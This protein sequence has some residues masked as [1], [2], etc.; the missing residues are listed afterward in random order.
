M[1][2][3]LRPAGFDPTK[4]YPMAYLIHGGPQSSWS[5][6][7]STR[8]NPQVYTGA[9]YVAVFINFHGSTSYGQE[10]TNSISRNWGSYPYEDIMAS[11][12][13]VFQT[14]PFIDSKRVAGLGASYGGYMINWLNGHTEDH[15]KCFVNHDGLFDLK[16]MYYST[17]ELYFPEFDMGG[18]PFDNP[19]L[20]DKWNPSKFVQKWRTPTLVIHGGKDYRVPPDQGFATFTALQRR[21]IPSRLLYF[22]DENHWVLK[23]ANSLRW[24]REVLNWIN[25]YTAA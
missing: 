20:Y 19:E 25:N 23:Q 2:W 24:H 8:W 7:F 21:G 15:F 12:K 14:Y 4:T 1:G 11:L 6:S 18:T 16:S 5:D 13:Y 10:F 9:G 3:L 22:P 17:E